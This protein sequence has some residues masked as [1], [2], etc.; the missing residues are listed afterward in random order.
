MLDWK[1]LS[2]L[3]LCM[4]APDQTQ[5]SI[6]KRKVPVLMLSHLGCTIAGGP[7]LNMKP[8]YLDNTQLHPYQ[9]IHRL[10][11]IGTSVGIDIQSIL[12]W[13]NICIMYLVCVQ[14]M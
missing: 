8:F 1:S 2:L 4:V 5:L 7:G 12:Y 11:I 6:R 3:F 10:C 9:K 14:Y 13:N